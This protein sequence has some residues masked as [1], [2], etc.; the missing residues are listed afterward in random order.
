LDTVAILTTLI[1]AAVIA[2]CLRSRLGHL[3]ATRSRRRQPGQILWLAT[4]C[5]LA[6][7]SPLLI[8]PVLQAQI[9]RAAF[10]AAWTVVLGTYLLAA[11]VAPAPAAFAV[12]LTVVIL[13]SSPGLIAWEH[14]VL[15][16]VHLSGLTAA[17]GTVLLTIAV[18]TNTLASRTDPLAHH[19]LPS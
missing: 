17:M 3:E 7:G 14:N 5:A 9:N 2:R 6:A 8:T 10:L 1:P 12:T 13:F 11:A 15:Y 4:V 18:L 19:G 16:N